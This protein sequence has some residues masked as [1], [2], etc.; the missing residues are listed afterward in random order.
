MC[1]RPGETKADDDH[2]FDP[3]IKCCSIV[4]ELSNF[5]VGGI[6]L[7]VEP[8]ED[9]R[10]GRES[11]V[12]RIAE[13]PVVTPLGLGQSPLFKLVYENQDAFGRSPSLRC[14]HYMEDTGRCGIRRHRNAVCIVWYCKHVRGAVGHAFW[15]DSLE[16]LLGIV[17]RN[18]AAWCI[19][20]LDIGIEALLEL[21]GA[22]TDTRPPLMTAAQLDDRPD[23][24]LQRRIWGR[25]FGRQ[26]DFFV[27]CARLVEPL[28]WNRVIG[29]CGSQA[30]IQADLT[31]NAYEKLISDEIPPALKV[32]S[33]QLVRITNGVS[34]VRTY[35]QFDPLDI[36]AP[37]MESLG[38]FDGRPT[39]EALKAIAA[40]KAI[41][42]DP[43]LVRKLCDFQVLVPSSVG[44]SGE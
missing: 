2:F 4:P 19:T 8:D 31:L 25:W 14:P 15:R 35:S 10:R 42:L 36:P 27:E 5:L 21:Y 24:A 44:Q 13:G 22:T 18:L 38:Y 34:R 11:I 12:R 28:S 16:H 33:L 43:G 7:E 29:I 23:R 32:G 39:A 37:V 1:A 26:Q 17:E 6:L 40:D 9:T 30:R 41:R 3:T 20:E